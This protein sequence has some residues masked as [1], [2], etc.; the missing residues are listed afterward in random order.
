MKNTEVDSFLYPVE[1]LDYLMGGVVFMNN[2]GKYPG[3]VRMN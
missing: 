2:T 3:L 1:D